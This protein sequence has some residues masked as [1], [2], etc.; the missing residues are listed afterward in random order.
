MKF[1]EIS[2]VVETGIDSLTAIEEHLATISNQ[3]TEISAK[4]S[5]LN[6]NDIEMLDAENLLAEDEILEASPL[7]DTSLFE[8]AEPVIF[9]VEGMRDQ[10]SFSW[11]SLV[12]MIVLTVA[13][14]LNLGVNLWLAFS[15][16]WR[17]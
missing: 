7:L 6:S 1:E 9:Q 12:L 13:L 2:E 5:E 11:M 8:A 15:D 3:L 16:K 17:S 14:M 10:L 4:Q